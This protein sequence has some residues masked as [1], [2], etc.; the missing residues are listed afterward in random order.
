MTQPQDG[1]VSPPAAA[2]TAALPPA[3]VPVTK[4]ALLP[5]EVISYPAVLTG[6]KNGQLPPN[7][8]AKASGISGGPVVTLVSVALRAW[9]AMVNDALSHGIILQAT[10]PADSYRPLAVQTAIFHQRYTPTFHSGWVTRKCGSITYYQTP[11]TASAACPGTSNHGLGIAIDVANASGGRLTW[12]LANAEKFGFSWEIQSESWHI[13]Y[14]TGDRIP[15]AVLRFEEEDMPL[16]QADAELVANAVVVKFLGASGPT[17]G[18]ALQTTYGLAQQIAAKVDIDP[19]ELAAITAAARAG[20]VE[21]AD[22]IAAAVLA[23]LP[24]TVLT[25]DDVEAAVRSVFLDGGTE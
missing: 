16:T 10:S 18:V 19:A 7:I 9:N 8:L 1:V 11:G 12:L 23:R 17:V 20:A 6:K 24:A 15:A 4:E 2:V 21:S 22:A 13:R 25:R 5:V 14:V 3:V